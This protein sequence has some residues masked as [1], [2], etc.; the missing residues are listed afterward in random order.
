MSLVS[1]N[2]EIKKYDVILNDAKLEYYENILKEFSDWSAFKREIKLSN[3]LEGKRVQ[4][5]IENIYKKGLIWGILKSKNSNNHLISLKDACF[6]IKS[7]HFTLNS[8][9][10]EKLTLGIKPLNTENGKILKSIIESD[11]NLEI[12][13]CI[14]DD[15]LKYFYIQPTEQAA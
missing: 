4:F 1:I 12:Y 15:E 8:N 11:I 10:I 2:N 6:D 9:D 5:D 14:S 13:Q 3:L 7:M